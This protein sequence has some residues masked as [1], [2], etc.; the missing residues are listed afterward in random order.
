M[1]KKQAKVK[2]KPKR[3]KSNEEVIMH[4]GRKTCFYCGRQYSPSFNHDHCKKYYNK[5]IYLDDH[6]MANLIGLYALGVISGFIVG[7]CTY[8]IAN[9]FQLWCKKYGFPW[10]NN[11]GMKIDETTFDD[12][13][14]L[15]LYKIRESSDDPYIQGYLKNIK[16]SYAS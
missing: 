5:P 16:K 10:G 8:E 6:E 13:W 3:D 2:V 15:C 9:K 1:A 7:D 14:R 4:A 11:W 12:D